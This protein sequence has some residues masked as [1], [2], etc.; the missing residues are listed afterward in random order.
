MSQNWTGAPSECALMAVRIQREG[1]DPL[2]VS[3]VA[4]LGQW[5]VTEATNIRGRYVVTHV[6]TG[7]KTGPAM[8][9]RDAARTVAKLRDVIVANGDELGAA[10]GTI[11]AAHPKHIRKYWAG[12]PIDN[13]KAR[14]IERL[15]LPEV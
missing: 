14:R 13:P 3:A 9:E 15:I 12:L 4:I 6:P 5:A 10:F 2:P 1:C 11:V 8:T 7:L